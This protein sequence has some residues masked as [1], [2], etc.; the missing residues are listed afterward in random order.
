MKTYL[1][2]RSEV[3]R[4]REGIKREADSRIKHI[5]EN[6]KVKGVPRPLSFEEQEEIENLQ[7]RINWCKDEISRLSLN[8]RFCGDWM[9]CIRS[10]QFS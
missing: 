7:K 9:T 1:R 2:S 5:R 8:Q 4:M 3:I 6:A 10:P